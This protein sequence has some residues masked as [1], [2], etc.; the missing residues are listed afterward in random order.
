S[1]I[2]RHLGRKYPTRGNDL[3]LSLDYGLQVV[4]SQQLSGRRGA[5]VAIDPRTGE[6]LA[7]VSSPSFNPNL[8]VT[9]INPKDYSSLRDNIDQ[10]LY[11][12]AVQGVY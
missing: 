8:F 9:G 3:Y 2:L 4:A 5:I 6:I 11:N 7:L 12:R 10:P 1:N